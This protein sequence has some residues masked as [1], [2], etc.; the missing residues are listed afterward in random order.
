MT[1][2]YAELNRWRALP[3]RWGESDCIMVCMDWITRIYG[4]DPAADLRLT[5]ASFSECQRVTGFFTRP[6]D[7]AGPRMAAIG[8]QPTTTPVA[9]DFGI[10]LQ[11]AGQGV[12]RPH[13]ALCLGESW[14]VKTES[15]VTAFTPHKLL[16]AWG[17]GYV[18]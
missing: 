3:F 5:Y 18:G 9:G 10:V 15:G 16:A 4:V 1:P 12:L 17:V 2:L 7:I 6:L 11:I 14:A 13:G 8:L